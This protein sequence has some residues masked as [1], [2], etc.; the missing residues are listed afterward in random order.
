MPSSPLSMGLASLTKK[1]KPELIDKQDP[2]WAWL[3][4]D[5]LPEDRCQLTANSLMS[6]EAVDLGEL[7]NP[8][9]SVPA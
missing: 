6:T 5:F 9:Y 1:T 3:F 2:P 7:V 8:R 4:L